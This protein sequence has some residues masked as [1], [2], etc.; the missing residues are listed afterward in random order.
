MRTQN[1]HRPI[2]KNP[3]RHS[4]TARCLP[5]LLCGSVAFPCLGALAEEPDPAPTVSDAEAL[6]AGETLR[7]T[8]KETLSAVELD[9]GDTLV[10]LLRDG[11]SVELTVEQT[12]AEIIERVTPGG[13]VHSF[14]CRLR[15]DGQPLTL[16][17]YV[18]SQECFYEPYVVNG[19]RIW[20]DI[21][22]D[23]FELVPV[24]YPRL[25]NL[26]C[27]PRKDVRLA[28]QDATLRICPQETHPWLE[29]PVGFIDVG[30]CYNG[31]DC[32]LGA[33]EG[34]ALHVGLDINHPKGSPLFAPIDFDTQAYF[35]SLAAGDNNNRW[36]GIRRWP[37]GDVWALQTHHLIELLQPENEPLAAGAKYATTAGVHV[38]RHEHTHFEFKIGRKHAEE[39]LT[40]SD[41]PA[42]IACPI[43]FDDQ[44]EAAQQRPEV[45][46]LDPW[47]IFWQTFEDQ[48]IRDGAIR[49]AIAPLAPA[50]TGRPVKFSPAG[51]RPGSDGGPLRFTWTFGDGGWSDDREPRHTFARPGVYPVTLV[52]EDGERRATTTQHMTVSGEPVGRPVLALSAPEEP[53]FRRRPVEVKHVYGLPVERVPHTLELL[54][55]PT[56]PQPRARTVAIE[57]LGGGTLAPVRVRIRYLDGYGG[58]KGDGWLRAEVKGHDNE[59]SLRVQ[60][61]A[62]GLAPGRY[63]ARVEVRSPGSLNAAQGFRVALHVGD[64]PPAEG[65]VIVDDADRGCYATPYFWVG[66][67]FSRC[68]PDRRGYA[69]FYRT[70][71]GRAV[72]GEFVRFTPDL[73]A[74][75]YR[76]AFHDATPF[77]PES[78][79]T[80]RV[81]HVSG[82]ETVRVQ[83]AADRSIGTFT[84]DE[85][86]DGWIEILAEHSDGLVVA[87]AMVFT[88]DQ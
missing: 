14:T 71:G 80:V 88:P 22:K 39:P 3:L 25:G 63:H 81:R 52:V 66:H 58:R 21:V 60:A 53:S 85:G 18:C 41:D 20:L 4:L 50:V 73:R 29:E 31:D 72:P 61:D 15:V 16:R 30:R 11:R 27:V 87:D 36:R 19:V 84:F 44:S 55:R 67:R 62:A 43:D 68:P 5:L 6:P 9:R 75:S 13:I 78:R 33:Y 47:I 34:Q 54:A 79:F 37:D 42:S 2:G 35:N 32:Y 83:P 26:Q 7:L 59:Q 24:R 77:P 65:E 48:K 86:M 70:N 64:G 56:R 76:V 49:A 57:N 28:L 17:R 12:A 82:I 40:A 38:G 8:A 23:V 1:T 46:H 69:G 45:L 51:S 74:G 10:F